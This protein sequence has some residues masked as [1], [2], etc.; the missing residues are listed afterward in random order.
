MQPQYYF[1]LHV[2][3]NSVVPFP[4]RSRKEN[5]KLKSTL[6]KSQQSLRQPSHLLLFKTKYEKF[7]QVFPTL[8]F[9]PKWLFCL[10]L[11]L[12]LP[13]YT[14]PKWHKLCWSGKQCPTTWYERR[15]NNKIGWENKVEKGNFTSQTLLKYWSK[16]STNKWMVSIR[17][18][19]LSVESHPKTKY[20][21]AYLR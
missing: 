5:I 19:S 8:S 6:N 7:T 15:E 2:N 11:E 16:S 14:H 10:F 18:S 1:K 13:K 21:P 17:R 12:H 4:V 9:F 20:K 3:W